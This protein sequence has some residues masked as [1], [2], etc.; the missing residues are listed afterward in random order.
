MKISAFALLCLLLF[1]GGAAA[2]HCRFDGTSL[3]VIHLIN[4]QGKSISGA[5]GNLS[6]REIDNPNPDS[7]KY[8][9]GLLALPFSTP[10]NIFKTFDYFKL[11]ELTDEYC[12]GCTFLSK[13]YYAVKLGTAE[14]NCI[15]EK[16][17]EYDYQPRK[18]EVVYNRGMISQKIEVPK[19]SI[20]SLC[21]ANGRWS[22]IKPLDLKLT[23]P[24]H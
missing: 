19:D 24:T 3:V 10:L 16:G 7:C 13:G 23:E 20:Y 6:L 15:I 22:R 2:Q 1:A 21:V 12:E 17:N 14:D 8:T 5:K 4:S 11:S 18:F 9:K